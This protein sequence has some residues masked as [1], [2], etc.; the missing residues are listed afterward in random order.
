[1][2]VCAGAYV[3]KRKDDRK[4]TYM[5]VLCLSHRFKAFETVILEWVQSEEGKGFLG[6]SFRQVAY[7]LL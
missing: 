5:N 4:N 3:R 6:A 7:L 1:M 2:F